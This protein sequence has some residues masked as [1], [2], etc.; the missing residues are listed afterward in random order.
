[1]VDDRVPGEAAEE[2]WCPRCNRRLP[3]FLKLTCPH[4][5]YEMFHRRERWE[6]HADGCRAGRPPPK[7]IELLDDTCPACG[8]TMTPVPGK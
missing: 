5:H 2:D 7:G 4:C 8:A 1:M 3:P 6:G